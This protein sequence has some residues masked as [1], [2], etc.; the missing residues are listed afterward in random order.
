MKRKKLIH[1][2]ALFALSATLFACGENAHES[3]SSI[4]PTSS[5]KGRKEEE[6][7]FQVCKQGRDV[8][9]NCDDDYSTLE[10]TEDYF[11][12]ILEYKRSI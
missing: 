3:S 6:E 10:T 7:L 1:V 2:V 5:E 11:N 12:G 9:L 4:V 8:S